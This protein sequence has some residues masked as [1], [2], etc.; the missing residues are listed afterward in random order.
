MHKLTLSRWLI[1]MNEERHGTP[2]IGQHYGNYYNDQ[3]CIARMINIRCQDRERLLLP[4]LSDGQEK[5][6]NSKAQM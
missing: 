5:E 6:L 3:G 1:D 2:K 4:W